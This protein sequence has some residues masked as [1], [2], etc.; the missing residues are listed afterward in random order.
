[1]KENKVI[2]YTSNGRDYLFS[3]KTIEN[4]SKKNKK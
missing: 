4:L 2:I 3:I 1:M